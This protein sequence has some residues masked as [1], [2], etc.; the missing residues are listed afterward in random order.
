MQIGEAA[1]VGVQQPVGQAAVLDDWDGDDGFQPDRQRFVGGGDH[2]GLDGDLGPLGQHAGQALGDDLG[3]AGGG[4]GDGVERDP[5]GEDGGVFGAEAD[6]GRH[7]LQG[8]YAARADYE[9]VQ[10]PVQSGQ[11][12]V[13]EQRVAAALQRGHGAGHSAF[14]PGLRVEVGDAAGRRTEDQRDADGDRGADREERP[15]QPVARPG[16]AAQHDDPDHGQAEQHRRRDPRPASGGAAAAGQPVRA[17]APVFLG[18][19][20]AGPGTG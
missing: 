20:A 9:K 6:P 2:D 10:M 1:W 15:D 3:G 7:H 12:P 18:A 16:R 8:E 5:A 13:D 17:A 11:C 4:L 19:R 14:C